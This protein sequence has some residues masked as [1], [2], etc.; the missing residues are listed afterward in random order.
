MYHLRLEMAIN[1][2]FKSMHTTIV[3]TTRT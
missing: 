1:V 3:N 2:F